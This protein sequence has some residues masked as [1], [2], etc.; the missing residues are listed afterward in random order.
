MTTN[1]AI[2]GKDGQIN[3]YT[4]FSQGYKQALTTQTPSVTMMNGQTGYVSDTSQTPF[5]ISVIPVVG[6]FPT[7]PQQLS[8]ASGI[9]PD[10]ADQR[11]QAMLQAQADAKAQAANQAAAEAQAGGPVPP[12]PP[13]QKPNNLA[14]R[15]KKRPAPLP[16]PDEAAAQRLNAAQEST[17]G[18][19]A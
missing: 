16:T 8:D 3:F 2:G 7:S 19:P 14:P 17:A 11:I 1:F 5:V 18:R 13:Q 9:Q 15:Q 10:G 12:L 6:A 4:N